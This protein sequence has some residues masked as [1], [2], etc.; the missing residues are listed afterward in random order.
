M[1]VVNVSTSTYT[2]THTAVFVADKLRTLIR[3]L[4]VEYG[5]S[6]EKLLDAWNDWV[7]EAAQAWL[8]SGHLNEVVVEFYKPGSDSAVARW[9]FPIAYDGDSDDEDLWVD[10]AFFRTSV[11][12]AKRPP[13][14]CTYRIVLIVASGAPKVYGVSDTTLRS[15]AQLTARTQGTVLS[16]RDIMASVRTYQ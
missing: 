4:I 8:I 2:R 13:A 9:D 11:L 15:V 12:K 10:K 6:T 1:T 16:T 5:L 14:N 7:S 3:I